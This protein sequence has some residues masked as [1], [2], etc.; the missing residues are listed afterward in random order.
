MNIK[1]L[2]SLITRTLN[3]FHADKFVEFLKFCSQGNMH[4]FSL[5]NQLA[6]FAQNPN[7]TVAVGFDAWKKKN[8]FPIGGSGISIFPKN[9]ASATGNI[10]GYVF[11]VEDTRAN[12]GKKADIPSVSREAYDAYLLNYSIE[13]SLKR[14]I[15]EWFENNIE[16]IDNAD[17]NEFNR[18][19]AML[20]DYLFEISTFIVYNKFG[21]ESVEFS[22]SFSGIYEASFFN[23]DG[24]FKRQQFN[25]LMGLVQHITHKEIIKIN[26][27]AEDY[28]KRRVYDE[29]RGDVRRGISQ[30]NGSRTNDDVRQGQE[31][32]GEERRESQ[33]YGRYDR[34]GSSSISGIGSAEAGDN[35]NGKNAFDKGIT[36]EE[37]DEVSGGKVFVSGTSDDV[38]G[39]RAGGDTR[40]E[41][42]SGTGDVRKASTENAGGSESLGAS[43]LGEDTGGE[44]D[45]SDNQG[46]NRQ[47]DFVHTASGELP[48]AVRDNQNESDELNDDIEDVEPAME[49][50][51]MFSYLDALSDDN[52]SVSSISV[53]DTLISSESSISD[54]IVDEVLKAG[55]CGY[56]L[57]SRAMVFSYYSTQWGNIETDRA[58]DY[59]KSWY[60]T[61]GKGLGF[62][63]N[64][65][66]I[67]ASY[68]DDGLHLF[69]GD[70]SFGIPD[71]L[72]SWDEIEMHIRSM[73]A[74][75][76]FMDRVGE[77]VSASIDENSVISEIEY[78]F[79]D[80]FETEGHEDLLPTFLRGRR[81]FPLMDEELRSILHNPSQA[82]LLLDAAKDLWNR[83]EAGEIPSGYRYAHKYERIE[84]LERYLNGRYSF[85]F[86]DKISVKN[87]D[88]LPINS[89]NGFLHYTSDDKYA[90]EKRFQMFEASDAG[91]NVDELAKY[92]NKTYGDSGSGNSG[93]DIWH[94]AKG[95]Q[96]KLIASCD[97]RNSK[98]SRVVSNRDMA[99]Y[100]CNVIKADK[101]FLNADEKGK[102]KEWKSDKDEYNKWH[103]AF[104][105]EIEKEKEKNA[106][107]SEK[108]YFDPVS[109]TDVER[110]VL[111]D[112]IIKRAIDS[113]IFNGVR[114]AMA[115]IFSSEAISFDEKALFMNSILKLN[116]DKLIFLYGYDFARINNHF[117]DY[118]AGIDGKFGTYQK[119]N[120]KDIGIE[121]HVFPQNYISTAGWVNRNNYFNLSVEELTD[122]FIRY[123][124]NNSINMKE[125]QELREEY[126]DRYT[127][128]IGE[129][130]ELVNRRSVPVNTSEAATLIVDAD[131][132]LSEIMP[133]EEFVKT[134]VSKTAVTDPMDIFAPGRLFID[135]NDV[136]WT[137]KE[138][139]DFKLELE[140]SAHN[141]VHTLSS[142]QSYWG[143]MNEVDDILERELHPF[144]AEEL[145]QYL[146]KHSAEADEA[147]TTVAETTIVSSDN[148]ENEDSVVL[149]E[150]V[151]DLSPRNQPENQSEGLI[152]HYP[153]DWVPNN[154]SAASRFEKN[155][156][157]IS[158]LKAVEQG[159]IEL[160]GGVQ[161]QLAQY[162]GWG[163]LSMY[164][165]E[166]KV[167]LAADRAKL[168]ALL[169][170][171][172]Y[173]SARSSVTDS[174]YTP[175]EVIDGIYEAIERF[176]FKGGK[177][178]EPS[179]G[180]GNF[181]NAIPENIEK[182]SKLYG[183][184]VD[185]ISGRIAKLLHPNADI[186]IKGIENANVKKNYYDLIIGNVPF[187]EFKVF[188][189]DFSKENF[190][191]HDYFFAK[192]LDLCTPGGLVAFI[193]SKGTLDKRNDSVR[194][195]ISERA[196]FVGA[197]RLPNTAFADSADTE[198]TTDIIFL[199][200][201]S[202]PSLEEQEFVSVEQTLS[203]FPL[204]SY[205]VSNPDMMLGTMNVD[206]Q[207]YGADR[208]LTYLAPIP[209]SNL[210]EE[211]HTAIGSL[212]KDIYTENKGKEQTDKGENAD[213]LVADSSVKNYTYT[214]IDG[215]VYMREDNELVS[216]ENTLNEKQKDRV[217]MLCGI[218]TILHEL[219]DIQLAGCSDSQLSECQ[220]RLS[221]SYDA[222]VNK[223]GYINDN[224][225]KQAFSDDVEY[226]LL[227]ALEDPVR[228]SGNDTEAKKYVKAKIFTEQTI[229]PNKARESADNA[230]E[231]LNITV[232]D[233]GYVNFENIMA[234]Y[235]HSFE[236][237]LDELNGEI[238]LNPD[239]AD[240]SD[241][242][243]GYETKE[244]YLSGDVRKKLA[245]ANVA[246]L[247]DERY[248]EN[249]AALE[250]V[251]P[252]DLDASD[253]DAKIGAN[254]IDVTDY[255]KFMQ[256]KFGIPYWNSRNVYIEYLAQE[257]SYF[258]QGKPLVRSVENNTT[259]GTKRMDA[260]EIFETL[261]NMRQVQVKD[262]VE[263]GDKVTYVL[264]ERETLLAKDKAEFIKKE[265]RDWLFEDPERRE[266]YVRIYNDRFN[267]IKLREY[268][269][270]Y[271]T[272]PG[273]NPELSLRPYQKNAVARIIRGGNTL[274][275][276]CVGAGKSYEMAAASM[277]LKRLGLANKPM[278]VV[279]NHLTGQMAKEFLDL[280]PSANI[281]LTRKED[282]EKSN[283]K[284]F[285]S[286]IA[287]GNYDAVII[288]HSQ[289]EKIA[290]SKERQEEYI[291]R[292]IEATQAYISE[293]KA[294]M[295]QRWSVK[296]ME[297][298]EKSLRA[299]LEKLRRED[300]KDDVLSFEE[301]GVDALMVDEAHNYKNL[302]FSTKIGNVAGINPQGSLKAYD[303]SLKC[304]YIN[305]LHPGRNVVFA[306]GTPISNTMCEMYIMQ[307]YLQ[308]DMLREKGLEHFDAW[309]A[310]YGEVV[311]SME[312]S[313]EGKG[314]RPK[315]RFAKFTN[316]PELVTSFRMCADIQTQ[317]ML[318][319]LN[320]PK[321]AGGKY[322][323]VECEAS[324]DI[325]ACIDEFVERA[326]RIRNGQ[327]DSKED[328]MLKI[329]HDAKLV[330]TDIRLY[331][332]TADPDVDS[333]LYKCVEN[334]YK[335]YNDTMDTKAAQV[336]FS[337]I[338]VPN[339]DKS[340]FSVYQFI[341]DELVKRG[342]PADEIC[343]I[344][345]AKKDKEREEMF[346]DMRS[347]KKRII[348][349][350]TEK[351]GTGTN[352]QDRLYAMHEIDVPWRPS[353]VEQ[354]EGRIL[355]FGNMFD[356][357]HIFRYVT[358]GT[359]D[360]YNW[361]IIENKQRFIS[362]VM[363]DGTI[364]RTC[365][366]IDEAV[367]N[368]AEMK[369]I[370]SGNPLIKEK[371]EVD[372]DVTRLNLLKRNFMSNKYRLEDD[373]NT[374]IPQKIE[375]I[376]QTIA[377]ME[378][379]IELYN[380][381][382]YAQTNRG[383]ENTSNQ[384]SMF[385]VGTE[386]AEDNTPFEMNIH[387]VVITERK[388]AGELIK[389]LITK[390]PD[391]GKVVQFGEFAGFQLG[392]SK[393]RN[394]MTNETIAKFSIAGTHTYTCEANMLADVGNIIRIQNVLKRLENEINDQKRMLV[395]CKAALE[396]SQSEYEKAF[397]QE[398]ELNRLL[399]RQQELNDILTVDEKKTEET[400]EQG[401]EKTAEAA[402]NAEDTSEYQAPMHRAM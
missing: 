89:L 224:I 53:S 180:I 251:V 60:D 178:L 120:F 163:G 101:F 217:K 204:N 98:V 55:A 378:K 94:S 365:E 366:D 213:V 359:F 297:A 343:F 209:G 202:T 231:A 382:P 302:S 71:R 245:S 96:I 184:E 75:N 314:Y 199:Q 208:A 387:G 177:I 368:Y 26:Q 326:G 207:R 144:N 367:L 205:F 388:K 315:T 335:I 318:P 14:G 223:H 6:I 58:R 49:Q 56:N 129:Y 257:N 131:E 188:D 240:E 227:C 220:N 330:S 87:I 93:L 79:L 12:D 399:A 344:H 68:H 327:I 70:P 230:I 338:G 262:R 104:A 158:L 351:M 285:V 138:V 369:A 105:R 126:S 133:E 113:S 137:V 152:Y 323:I 41:G 183:V 20:R 59:I 142:I 175:K 164:F 151:V 242:Y 374:R 321:L 64:N 73:I 132:A 247:T 15:E 400:A 167:D 62:T 316:L 337:D 50:V 2:N 92:I 54:D 380:K 36:G 385:E 255:Q 187:G 109:L 51:T 277:E 21:F 179:M 401:E 44:S 85:D 74:E 140:V 76:R 39:R 402:D 278:I 107:A 193:T 386:N 394:F 324:E 305:E 3:G 40:S 134:E 222:Y 16:P 116:M 29:Q 269:G 45:R 121:F 31:R 43:G 168:K 342:I 325:K 203:G 161:A 379:D 229:Y 243:A 108:A 329:C 122:G 275:G 1:R 103:D 383:T 143:W 11:D 286:K 381:S 363:T 283:R 348:I 373:I 256:E 174:F 384:N 52:M 195:Y 162:V 61:S 23:A 273:M 166:S 216:K 279:P 361:S 288:G 135:N 81:N 303:L 84:H 77:T 293:L 185:S 102:Y 238:Y 30:R 32:V 334:V 345:D 156:T 42:E 280:Y 181:Y 141:K 38:P 24:T 356:E 234:L 349:G 354:R 219:I 115:S 298:Q 339:A 311:T 196:D 97:D 239:K 83:C 210:S 201:K 48:G 376:E 157:A 123:F 398:E 322:D 191:I 377:D 333:K 99:R 130:T 296:Q 124:E 145:K 252:P 346:A 22:N 125:E 176:G 65:R 57:D 228:D 299:Q 211:L 33:S 172:E 165:D 197:I 218:R 282:F 292:Q 355:R 340:K 320:I 300:Y 215:K 290:I 67:S 148:P 236:D 389:A 308:S 173:K 350:S 291:E 154:G 149:N 370:S 35:G 253:I 190:L 235:P 331:D 19:M 310:N 372:A 117:I 276:H 37:S 336:I 170:D 153:D 391:D 392:I 259:Y 91:N 119:S 266:K 364:G 192:A 82:G 281:L 80:G 260:L 18:N 264:N 63:F 200:K 341:K 287:T 17:M 307:K 267:N 69:W 78:F 198:A 111:K 375:R 34:G 233:Y 206:T 100:I 250:T 160:D 146:A 4:N 271:L 317:S 244:E 5:A 150:V 261:L 106:E 272:F 362:Q 159:N 312:L 8:R 352:I 301:L 353:D 295:H 128:L 306:T 28:E 395:E 319:F 212:P 118:S 237:I 357:V 226:T 358:K 360:A 169:T 155:L 90:V 182:K 309:A 268:D 194:K 232:A 139:D 347:G 114:V 9:T 95:F 263:N 147:K 249:I 136:L 171:E 265:F 393:S 246:A 294:S 396:V 284:R 371:M 221:K 72:I 88:F 112:E 10:S 258:I 390:V 313:P 47:G 248:R 186:Q 7:A 332:P 289:F 241:I 25:M 127:A 225:A 189:K 270:S 254:W 304:Q 27:Y 274:L 328:N 397:P 13:D 214:I 86:T 110:E 66:K 46:D